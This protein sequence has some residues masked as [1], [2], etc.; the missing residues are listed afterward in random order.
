MKK[1]ILPALMVGL[2][3]AC[4][5]DDKKSN[6]ALIGKWQT[7]KEEQYSG[8]DLVYSDIIEEENISCPDYTEFKSDGNCQFIEMDTNCEYNTDNIG[9]YTFDGTNFKITVEGESQTYKMLSLT[10][11][12]MSMQETYTENGATIKHTIFFKKLK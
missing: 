4:S 6:Q 8:N 5:D 2:L 9:P 1:I 3:T 10:A 7:I 12:E 11:T